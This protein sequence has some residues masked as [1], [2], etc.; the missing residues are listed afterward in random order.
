[1]GETAT[2]MN[3]QS[4]D[5]LSVTPLDH[6]ESKSFSGKN[7]FQGA[8][9][10]AKRFIEFYDWVKFVKRT[11]V[12]AVFDGII[13]IFLFEIE[14]ARPDI[15]KYIW[16]LVGDIPPTYIPCSDARNPYEALD[17]YIGAMEEWVDAAA[18]GKSVQDLIPVNVPANKGN[19]D[20]LAVRLKFLDQK[21]LPNLNGYT[22]R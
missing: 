15:D 2:A 1:M 10:E 19:A 9:S 11:W 22:D 12:G 5:M 20:N 14:R 6:V 18:Q 16:V 7:E 13:Y 8:L 17:G 21:V 4:P 3:N